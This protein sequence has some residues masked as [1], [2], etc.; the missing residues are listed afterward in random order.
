[1]PLPARGETDINAQLDAGL[2]QVDGTVDYALS[3]PERQAIHELYALYDQ[4]LGEPNPRLDMEALSACND[5]LHNA[6]DQVQKGGR[7]KSM[8]GS[9]LRAVRE[10]PLCGAAPATTLDHH[11][12][13]AQ[14]KSLAINPRNLVPSCQ[15]CNRAKGTVV[16][17]AGQGMVHAYFQA[18]PTA[19][20]LRATSSYIDG[21]LA[22]SF[23][24]D[25]TVVP[26]PL[27]ERLTFQL[28]RL[29]LDERLVD[30]INIMLFTLKPSLEMFRGL[31]NERAQIQE[32]LR[33]AA[34][35][36]N[37]D[38][39]WNHWRS[40]VVLSLSECDAFLDDPWTYLDKPLI[41]T[42]ALEEDVG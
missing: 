6:Y 7:L 42:E 30:S 40:A 34:R 21:A 5:A 13:R 38:F 14:Y 35:S 9:L 15:P 24:I 27:H 29:N 11:L 12:P 17:S 16:P 25:D 37:K 26:S 31:A 33:G 4:L 2:I 10:C 19:T 3:D 32:Y 39:A 23:Y 18:L 1:M 8:R 22:I 20:F 41:L 36:Y 28:T